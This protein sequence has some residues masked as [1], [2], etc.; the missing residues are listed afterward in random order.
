ML[1]SNILV[2]FTGSTFY[3]QF[4][5]YL[6]QRY[7]EEY[8]N[9]TEESKLEKFEDVFIMGLNQA[10][11]LMNTNK[12][13]NILYN[14]KPPRADMLQKLG[15]II[16]QLQKEYGFPIIRPLRLED[17]IKKIIG[18]DPRYTK[19]YHDWILSLT[20]NS[21]GF[22]T[23]DFTFLVRQF[24]HDKIMPKNFT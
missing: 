1:N 15:N 9:F 23:I 16:Y 2:D 19:K 4:E 22:N 8:E 12:L 10:K 24:P 18:K 17:A 6:Q 20:N 13:C 7:S 5:E 3:K 21:A 14:D 11:K